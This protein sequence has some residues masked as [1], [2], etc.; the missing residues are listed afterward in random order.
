[1]SLLIINDEITVGYPIIIAG[2]QLLLCLIAFAVLLEVLLVGI[3][4]TMAGREE[5]EEEEW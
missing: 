4:V 3:H 2:L 1:M 5:E